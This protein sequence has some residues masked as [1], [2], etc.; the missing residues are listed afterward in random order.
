MKERSGSYSLQCLCRYKYIVLL[1][2][3]FIL[4]CFSSLILCDYLP[5]TVLPVLLYQILSSVTQIQILMNWIKIAS[6][7]AIAER[8]PKSIPD[9]TDLDHQWYIQVNKT[10]KSSACLKGRWLCFK[11]HRWLRSGMHIIFPRDDI[12]G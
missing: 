10:P 7:T 12:F 8:Y 3:R 9:L 2:A 5:S 1:M 6:D 4:G 11:V